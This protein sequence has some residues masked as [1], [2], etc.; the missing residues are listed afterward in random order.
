MSS[1]AS[2][3]TAPE[4]R[5]VIY[6]AIPAGLCPGVLDGFKA[7]YPHIAIDFHGGISTDLHTRFLADI[8]SRNPEV[9]L[10]WS[11]GM[12]LQMGLVRDGHAL[13]YA[14][15]EARDLPKT[16]V[17]QDLAYA[18]TAEPL[19]TLVNRERFD[20][21]MPAGSIGEIGTALRQDPARFRD[22]IACF[23]IPRNG[24]GFLALL[25]ESRREKRF[26]EFLQALAQ[27]RP[28]L[29]G[30]NPEVID[31]LASG[32]AALGYHILA[33]FARRAVQ[34]N[35]NLAIATGRMP[36]IRVSRVALISRY[37]RHPGAA[38][39]FVDYLLSHDGQR[40][41]QKDGLFPVREDVGGADQAET[42]ST[43]IGIT[44][45][46]TELLDENLR[47]NL[48]ERWQVLMAT[49]H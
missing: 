35:P 37:A 13:P 1:T 45:C 27:S 32:R 44:E 19:V 16:A 17:Y 6:S 7:R 31:H 15:A 49:A 18:T 43:P 10:F 40:E 48:L 28:K 14:S 4:N 3:T 29:C 22:A 25:Y 33:S 39:A 12:D 47:R 42:A 30:S 5:L 36:P 23:D 46:D 26:D 41:L 24:V 8:A 38:K 2:N 9:D 34:E 20:I 21:S 11:S